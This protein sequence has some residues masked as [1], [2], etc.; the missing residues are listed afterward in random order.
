MPEIETKVHILGFNEVCSKCGAFVGHNTS[1]M[2]PAWRIGE[3]IGVIS[4]GGQ[5]RSSY[6]IGKNNEQSTCDG[7]PADE[8]HQDSL[9]GAKL[10]S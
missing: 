2:T 8:F 1:P 3:Y 9:R 7:I 6:R 10:A 5:Y 4:Y